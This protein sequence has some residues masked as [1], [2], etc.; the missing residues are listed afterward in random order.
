MC[1]FNLQEGDD[2]FVYV[3]VSDIIFYW[4]CGYWVSEIKSENLEDWQ[5][6][7][8]IELIVLCGIINA[9]ICFI[10]DPFPIFK[11]RDLQVEFKSA[12]ED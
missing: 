9:F 12:E 1:T 5:V 11:N 3:W 8:L 2:V 4:W 6:S 7:V 10:L